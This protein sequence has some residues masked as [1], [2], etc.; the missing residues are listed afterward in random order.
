MKFTQK[1]RAALVLMVFTAIA[2]TSLLKAQHA[3]D[4]KLKLWYQQTIW[5]CLG[6]CIA[7]WK[8][9]LGAMVYGN[10]E[11]EILQLNEHTLWSGGPNRNDIPE[12]LD[13]LP[14][15]GS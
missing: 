5:Q 4:S 13:S 14:E 10:V 6:K 11:K 8:W 2:S 12:T 3:E 9:Q 1:V 15:I 7:H